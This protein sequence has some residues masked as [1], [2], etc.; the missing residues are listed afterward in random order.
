MEETKTTEV[1]SESKADKPSS[2]TTTT[3]VEKKGSNKMLWIILG[4][5]A[6]IIICC[7]VVVGIWYFF[8]NRAADTLNNLADNFPVTT[9]TGGNNNGG[10]TSDNGSTTGSDDS[11]STGDSTFGGFLG[12]GRFDE[13]I[14]DVQDDANDL[15]ITMDVKNNGSDSTTFSTLLFLSLVDEDGNTMS[16]DF[17][18]S[19]DE[20]Q[21]LDREIAGGE[22][23]RGKIAFYIE[24]NPSNLTLEVRDSLFDDT[25]TR[26]EL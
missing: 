14:G 20:D 25:P 10:S 17:F 11:S 5:V 9:T 2:S 12:D 24:G 21:R 19:I 4:I 8:V 23:F 22:T 3:K 6:L 13:S 18:Y 26:F 15:I 1:V 16:Q 7:L